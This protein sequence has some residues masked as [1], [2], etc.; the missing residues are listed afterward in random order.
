LEDLV[1]VA[2]GEPDALEELREIADRTGFEVA[3]ARTG[4]EA[5]EILALRRPKLVLVGN[6]LTD[7]NCL[8]VIQAVA[9][10]EFGDMIGVVLA[11]DRRSPELVRRARYMGVHATVFKPWGD[12]RV[13]VAIRAALTATRT[14]RSQPAA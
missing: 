8:A 6:I 13:D 1:I 3:A 5:V 4:R 11:M 7:M 2:H 10:H 9:N 14:A 12:G